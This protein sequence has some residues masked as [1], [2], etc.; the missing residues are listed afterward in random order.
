MYCATDNL[1][2]ETGH[3]HH[4]HYRHGAPAAVTKQRKNVFIPLVL[5]CHL[6][7]TPST[8]KASSSPSTAS[9]TYQYNKNQDY[10][11][12]RH[13]QGY[14][15]LSHQYESESKI[16]QQQQQHTILH[17]IKKGNEDDNNEFEIDYNDNNNHIDRAVEKESAQNYHGVHNEK[18]SIS[19]DHNNNIE[20]NNV[21]RNAKD[22]DYE[23]AAAAA[24]SSFAATSTKRSSIVSD[25]D[26]SDEGASEDDETDDETDDDEVHQESEDDSDEDDSDLDDHHEEEEGHN[27][28][29]SDNEEE[30]G[31]DEDV[32]MKMKGESRNDGIAVQSPSASTQPPLLSEG[33]RQNEESHNKH[34][35]AE[36]ASIN[37]HH[38]AMS[39]QN[40]SSSRRYNNSNNNNHNSNLDDDPTSS[41]QPLRTLKKLQAM[42]EE[43]DYATSS[44]M[45]L[46]SPSLA[47]SSTQKNQLPSAVVTKS[48]T[49]PHREQTM[50]RN[51]SQDNDVNTQYY[52]TVN[53]GSSNSRN[54]NTRQSFAGNSF[55][56]AK[57]E[58][59]Q[60][61]VSDIQSNYN[62]YEIDRL[63]TSK[64]RSKYKKRQRNNPEL[65]REREKILRKQRLKMQEEE[66]RQRRRQEQQIQQQQQQQAN[67]SDDDSTGTD[68]QDDTD[69]G[70][71][72]ILP[73]LPVYFSDAEST[74]PTDILD[75]DSSPAVDATRKSNTDTAMITNGVPEGALTISQTNIRQQQVYPQH[76]QQFSVHETPYAQKPPLQQGEGPPYQYHTHQQP[77]HPIQ[78]QSP[79][80]PNQYYP[81]QQYQQGSQHRQ[82]QYSSQPQTQ[83]GPYNYNYPPQSYQYSNVNAYGPANQQPQLMTTQQGQH[84][85]QQQHQKYGA[86]NGQDYGPIVSNYHAQ[87]QMPPSTQQQFLPQPI[88][89][90]PQL[91]NRINNMSQDNG[92]LIPKE[93]S[94]NDI[95]QVKEIVKRTNVAI[96]NS[97]KTTTASTQSFIESNNN[98]T[99]KL[100]LT[101]DSLHKLTFF[102]LSNVFLCYCAV[103][104]RTLELAEYNRAFRNNIHTASLVLIGPILELISIVERKQI[105]LNSLVSIY[106]PQ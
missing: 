52:K 31:L 45:T 59:N 20:N 47:S 19:T 96:E 84:Q 63:W 78:G 74:D 1:D 97:D 5:M 73:N 34:V 33:R 26:D 53:D 10:D 12:I 42:L 51:Q 64:D 21:D 55:H 37:N 49:T 24:A 72:Y 82:Y 35:N 60:K 50:Q 62:G 83:Q 100:C 61:D 30:Y 95:Q 66:E 99:G 18:E 23:A 65:Q 58:Q 15:V 54:R 81:Q 6:T 85:Y 13:D 68:G 87:H 76:Q 3:R 46:S 80:P 92:I 71:S 39:S 77:M 25:S 29:S 94:T 36:T 91:R 102:A 103:S 14:R 75:L 67:T 86:W 22:F 32:K 48:Y 16:V 105:D 44:S 40:I 56:D 79:I 90:Q 2:G 8:V 9:S 98:V 89:A 41:S 7:F 11:I 88:V 17:G 57:N 27:I 43:T 104:P 38:R 93:A 101:F 69:D 70:L 4:W 28:L 106:F